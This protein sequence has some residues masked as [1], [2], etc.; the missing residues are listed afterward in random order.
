MKHPILTILILFISCFIQAQT[1]SQAK[2]LYAKGAYKEAL[3][4][5]K[6]ALKTRPSDPSLNLWYGACL[7]ETG[8]MEASLPYLKIAGNKRL[9][10]AD[11]YLANY[12][13]KS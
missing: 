13:L 9:P 6:E 3:P 4:A 7:L 5:F 1:L 8:N 2:I 10:E 11:R 12:Y